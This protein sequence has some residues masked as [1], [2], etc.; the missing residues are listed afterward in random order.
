MINKTEHKQRENYIVIK[1][2]KG[3]SIIQKDRERFDPGFLELQKFSIPHI[4]TTNKKEK[5]IDF[6]CGKGVR[7]MS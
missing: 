2:P 4:K 7:N 6:I 1:S 5:N 3:L